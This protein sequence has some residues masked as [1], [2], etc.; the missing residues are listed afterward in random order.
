[1]T[2]LM[3]EGKAVYAV[4]L[5]FNKAFNKGLNTCFPQSSPTGSGCSWLGWVHWDQ[6]VLVKKNQ[7]TNLI[8]ILNQSLLNMGKNTF[9]FQILVSAAWGVLLQPIQNYLAVLPCKFSCKL[10]RKSSSHTTL[11]TEMMS[12][13]QQGTS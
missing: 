5:D 11:L 1:M 2:C 9:C 6:R 4:C 12:G 7:G 8:G 13:V 10:L 3:N